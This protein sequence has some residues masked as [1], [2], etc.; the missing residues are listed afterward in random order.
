MTLASSGSSNQPKPSRSIARA[1]RIRELV[2]FTRVLANFGYEVDPEGQDHEQQF[3]CDLHGD[4]QDSKKSARFYP[5]SNSIYCWACGRARDAI[6]LVREKNGLSFYDALSWLER[7]FELPELPWETDNTKPPKAIEIQTA[8]VICPSEGLKRLEQA[9]RIAGLERDL[10]V[11]R[12]AQYW[13][14]CDGLAYK[15]RDGGDIAGLPEKALA[16]LKQES[17]AL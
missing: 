10:P 9:L 7:R 12:L 11:E 15:L 5:S 8:R 13:E 1:D 14:A 6:A 17:A 16:R 4:G 2:P 3:S